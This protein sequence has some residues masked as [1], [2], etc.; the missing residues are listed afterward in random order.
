MFDGRDIDGPVYRVVQRCPA[1]LEDFLSYEVLGRRYD[2]RDFLRGSGISMTV[3]K[4]RAVEVARRFGLGTATA[5]LDLQVDGVVWA[6]SGRPGHITVWAT[7]E[8]LLAR[9]LECESHD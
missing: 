2:R 1:V 5:T 4:D 6:T 8:L 3:S 7:P 9:V